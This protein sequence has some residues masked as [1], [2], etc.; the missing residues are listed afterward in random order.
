MN[1]IPLR[2]SES[3]VETLQ[4]ELSTLVARRQEL[5]AQGGS[6]EL[7]EQNRLEIA[8]CQWELSYALIERY[9]PQERRA[10]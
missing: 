6:H 4:C 5:R 1:A 9:L 8:L 2:T 3:R 7:L 10:A